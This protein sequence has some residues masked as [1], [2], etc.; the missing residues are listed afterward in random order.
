MV[1][2]VGLTTDFESV[3]SALGAV[4]VVGDTSLRDALFLAGTSSL[5]RVIGS[6]HADRNR[7]GF[8]AG[9]EQGCYS[10]ADGFQSVVPAPGKS[11]K[12]FSG[13]RTRGRVTIARIVSDLSMSPDHLRRFG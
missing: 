5:D 8:I 7:C 1:G 11:S 12:L 9:S 3:R 4:T 6:A 2:R 13:L 10:L